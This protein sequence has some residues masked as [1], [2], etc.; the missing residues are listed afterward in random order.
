M[1]NY[2]VPASGV[3]TAGSTMTA[4]NKGKNKSPQYKI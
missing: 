3:L 4:E 1:V 2:L